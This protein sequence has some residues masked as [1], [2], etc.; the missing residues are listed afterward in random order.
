MAEWPSGTGEF[1]VTTDAVSAYVRAT[2]G[3]WTSGSPVPPT[4]ASVFSYAAVAAMPIKD[5]VVLTGQ[6]FEFHAPIALGDTLRTSFEV[7]DEFER[8]DRAFMVI[9]TRTVNQHGDLVAIG[10]ITR[11]LPRTERAA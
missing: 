7:T 9:T 5:G 8:R 4:L 11:M 2:G 6:D 10:R 1:E 3:T